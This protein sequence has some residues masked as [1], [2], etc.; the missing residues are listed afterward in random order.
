M[1]AIQKVVLLQELVDN[2]NAYA[3]GLDTRNWAMVRS[4]FADS[5]IIDYGDLEAG[6]ARAWPADDWVAH[7]QAVLSGFDATHHSITNHRL[8][9][10]DDRPECRAY[11]V[12][13]HVILKQPAVAEAG[14]DDICTVVG[15]YHNHYERDTDGILR[16]VYSS[17]R[18]KWSS[19]NPAVFATAAERAAASSGS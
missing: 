4:C 15:E 6:E 14:P 11:L 8:S 2:Y 10:Q 3:E 19:G 13:D 12:A 9:L 5:V 17:L 16:I 18:V 1:D 7:I